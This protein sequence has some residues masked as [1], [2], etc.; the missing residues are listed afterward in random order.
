MMFLFD[1]HQ[2]T[3]RSNIRVRLRQQVIQDSLRYVTLN[4]INDV[5]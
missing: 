2:N 1:P 3:F 4:T 5:T